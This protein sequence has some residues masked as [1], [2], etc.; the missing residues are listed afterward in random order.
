MV[1][2]CFT[3]TN[4]N[5]KCHILTGDNHYTILK[6]IYKGKKFEATSLSKIRAIKL[7]V[8]SKDSNCFIS[9]N[10]KVM[11]SQQEGYI[12]PF[13]SAVESENQRCAWCVLTMT[14][15]GLQAHTTRLVFRAHLWN[16]GRRGSGY[17]LEVQHL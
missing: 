9:L 7:S 16:I 1:D 8:F 14:S 13:S 12:F 15:S 17:K 11:G 3:K 10:T 2:N 5:H 4:P 6:Y